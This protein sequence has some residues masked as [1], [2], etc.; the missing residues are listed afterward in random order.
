MRLFRIFSAAFRFRRALGASKCPRRR[1]SV[2]TPDCCTSLLNRLKQESK[3]SPV[4]MLTSTK[5]HPPISLLFLPLGIER[6]YAAVLGQMPKR[7]CWAPWSSSPTPGTF[8]ARILEVAQGTAAF[9][10]AATRLTPLLLNVPMV[11]A[12]GRLSLLL[13]HRSPCDQRLLSSRGS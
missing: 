9:A 1:A 6:V 12:F 10:Y 5:K 11:D 2:K 7:L 8:G 4:L 3:P 13:H